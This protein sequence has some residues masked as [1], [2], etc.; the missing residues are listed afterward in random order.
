MA[1]F[2]QRVIEKH[3]KHIQDIDPYHAETLD[4]WAEN[5]ARGIYDSETQNDGEFIQRILIDVLG[6]VGSSN[7]LEWTVAKNQPVGKGNVDVALGHFTADNASILAPLELKG[8]KTRDLDA[9]MAG[10]N[11]TPVQQAWEYAMDAKGAQWVLV[12]NYREIRLYAVGYGRK[13]YETFD[14]S[15]L[16]KAEHYARFILLLSAKNLLEGKTLSLL[17]ESEKTEKNITNQLYADY[18]VLR[19][20]LIDTLGKDNPDK[21]PLDVIR[22]T[23]TILDRILFVAFAEDKGLLPDKTLEKAY[24]TQNP[25]IP[26]PVWENFK[27]LF[28]A[29]NKGNAALKIPG[30][31][32][33]LFADD[34][35]LNNLTISNELCEGFKR[36]GEYDFDSEV[37]VN[38]LGHIFEQSITDL[39]ELKAQAE[40]G[41]EG[42]E[43]EFDKKKSKRKK[44]G[45]FYTPAYITRYIVEQAVGGWLA[46]RRKEIGFDTLPI[47]TDDDFASIKIT[48][49]RKIKHERNKNIA[50]HIAAWEAYKEAMSQIKVLDPACGS[51]AFLNEVFDYLKKEGQTINNELA[52][53]TGEQTHLFRWDTHILANNIFGVDINRESVEITK[54][55]LW[56]KTANR[57]EKLTYLEN[58]IKVGNSLID[59][60]A[61]AGNLAF[62]WHNEFADIMG[63]GGF[64]VVVGNPPYVFLRNKNMD[65][66]TK[67]YYRK[68]YKLYSLKPRTDVYFFE[69][70]FSLLKIDGFIGFIAPNN[71]LTIG[72]LKGFRQN[73]LK[74]FDLI[75]LV[76][77]KD[78]V[79]LSA[80]V[81]TMIISA[82]KSQKEQIISV[83][84]L[85]QGKF[86]SIGQIP[87]TDFLNDDCIIS[88]D[89]FSAPLKGKLIQKIE[90]KSEKLETVCDISNGIVVY[91]VNNGAPPQ[92]REMA[93][94]RIYHSHTKKGADWVPYIDGSDLK[95]YYFIWSGTYVQYGKNIAEKRAS[96]TFN[97]SRV[98]VRVIPSKPPYSINAMLIDEHY[99]NDQNYIVVFNEKIPLHFIIG[100]LNSRLVSFWF[101]NKL[102]KMQRGLFPQLKAGELKKF[103]I[104]S[105]VDRK[106]EKNTASI[107]ENRKQL[108]TIVS[109][110]INLISV[111]FKNIT[112]NSKLNR[113]TTLN[114]GEFLCELE[115]NRNLTLQ[116][117]SEWMQHFDAEKAKALALKAEIDRLDREIDQLV[118]T[119]YG[120]TPDEIAIVEG[121]Q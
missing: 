94:N 113:W 82:R 9:I 78:K 55:S 109:S 118:Y 119:L 112:I 24:E 32:G 91:K 100:I 7:G 71:L 103:P 47:L 37:S 50:A 54:L 5:I 31:N 22:Y 38:I 44:D 105:T 76:N 42:E 40:T 62:D 97:R 57:N 29:I 98:L 16:R 101:V 121:T 81:D 3:A 63:A 34:A 56:L 15:S 21:D 10:R 93:K 90:E 87:Q 61:I 108:E 28:Q 49:K 53:L 67:L 96:I 73:L 27:G 110:L 70:S 58:N 2:H 83:Q 39:E 114:A 26:Q 25:F 35:D 52:R 72:S 4:K 59:A 88:Y 30:Y 69:R 48:G 23:Q 65:E 120:L 1:L 75:N 95:R 6:Y 116:E 111:V 8:A 92:T 18:K 46:D 85:I 68:Q 17:K 14:L 80:N 99:I 12:S 36:I 64:D 84:E 79:F 86:E 102:G 20:R 115:K 117:K 45:I 74:D 51:G 33:G 13:E 60:P 19:H 104:P 66:T 41:A 77:S 11:K 43:T 106:I 89:L 107:I